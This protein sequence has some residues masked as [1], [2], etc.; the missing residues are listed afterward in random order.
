MKLG[1]HTSAQVLAGIALGAAVALGWLLIWVGVDSPL[2]SIGIKSVEGFSSSFGL[3]RFIARGVREKG[4]EL[5]SLFEV[6]L[7]TVV[8]AW[9]GKGITGVKEIEYRNLLSRRN[10]EL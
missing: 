7:R 4:E 6:G 8:T 1:H 9:T 5:D 2:E 3:P 10:K